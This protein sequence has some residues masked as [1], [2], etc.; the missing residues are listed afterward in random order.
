MKLV[1]RPGYGAM[2]LQNT[3]TNR[4]V[5]RIRQSL[6]HTAL[7]I[8]LWIFIIVGKELTTGEKVIKRLMHVRQI[9]MFAALFFTVDVILAIHWHEMSQT[10]VQ[11]GLYSITTIM[12]S[13]L[14]GMEG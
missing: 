7:V 11:A 14:P 6:K 13:S 5:R 12:F 4:M 10:L 1:N 8:T 2:A 9:A 3:D